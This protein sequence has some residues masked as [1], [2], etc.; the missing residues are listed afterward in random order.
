M[1]SRVVAVATGASL[2]AQQRGSNARGSLPQLDIERVREDML[3]RMQ[4]DITNIARR[5]EAVED[6]VRHLR[7]ESNGKALEAHLECAELET[8]T[9]RKFG[10]I[11]AL[12]A[13]LRRNQ[14][15]EQEVQT[16]KRKVDVLERRIPQ[17]RP[18][19]RK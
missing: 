16:L 2:E 3:Y 18:S 17:I 1:D 7:V 14:D 8:K 9:Q 15:L 12:I 13:S 6:A 19:G 5:V 4:I 10:E 11:E